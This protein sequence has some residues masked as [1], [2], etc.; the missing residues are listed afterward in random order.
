VAELRALVGRL[1]RADAEHRR[2]IAEQ[3]AV[4][5]EL[6]GQVAELQRR[7]GADSSTSSRPPGSDS[8]YRKPKRTSSRTS[9]GRKPGKQPG[10]PGATM[11]LVED[12]DE[13]HTLDPGCC[14]SC[15]VDVSGGAV[16][17]VERRQITDVAPPPPP[18][19]TE[20]RI[21][22]RACPCCGAEAV[23]PAPA[24]VPARAQ[25][26]PRLLARAAELV[27]GH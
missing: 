20:Y 14:G 11:P 2:V 22:H 5:E 18:W 9:S 21:V 16:M 7:L 27:C 19:V 26:G 25:Y 24:V 3:A 23:A 17:G 4:I 1:Q 15:G 6:T 12:P 10:E 8:P 13:T